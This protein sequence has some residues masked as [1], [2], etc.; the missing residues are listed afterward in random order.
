MGRVICVV[1]DLGLIGVEQG[2]DVWDLMELLRKDMLV[3]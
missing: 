1:M 3:V 2:M